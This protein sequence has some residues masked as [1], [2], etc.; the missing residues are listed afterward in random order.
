MSRINIKRLLKIPA[1]EIAHW[2]KLTGDVTYTGIKYRSPNIY[3]FENSD[4]NAK[5]AI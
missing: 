2:N 5:I 1:R 3:I 4:Y